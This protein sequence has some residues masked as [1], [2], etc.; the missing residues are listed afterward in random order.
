M[1]VKLTYEYVKSKF[2]NNNDKLL[3]PEYLGS[4]CALM[5]ECSI[6]GKK[7]TTFNNYSRGK[8]CK[9]C[10]AELSSINQRFT[11]D[12]LREQ[13]KIKGFIL[14]SDTYKNNKDKLRYLCKIHGEM[15][16]SY[17]D[18]RNGCGCEKCGIEARTGEGCGKWQGGITPLT[19]MLR[20]YIAPQHTELIK[21][22]NYTCELSSIKG[23]YLEV[24]HTHSFNAILK[25]TMKILDLPIY[26]TI[27]DYTENEL[28]LIKSKFTEIQDSHKS[29]VL[30]K[31]LHDLFHME[32]GRGDNTPQQFQEFTERYANNEFTDQLKV[33]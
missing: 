8:R 1:A 5:Y 7:E 25:D 13:Y 9:E 24:H 2:D 15:V 3:S 21:S 4:K 32:F 20:N 27:A 23:G 12:Y 22:N 16:A 33:Y 31:E 6:H 11:V 10:A 28:R 29:I 18:F 30:S 17:A 26:Q 14:L 19:R